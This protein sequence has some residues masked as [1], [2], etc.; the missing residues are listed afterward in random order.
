MTER[1][2]TTTLVARPRGGVAV[3]LPF[4]PAQAWGHRE[5]YDLAGSIGGR[6]VRGKLTETDDGP[7]LLLGPAWCR[8]PA[9]GP[10]STVEVVLA[11]EGPQLDDLPHELQAALAAEPQAAAFFQA[12]PTYYRKNYVRPIAAAKRPQ[13]RERLALQ[14]VEALRE[15]RRER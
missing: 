11:P 13:T 1:R 6:A 15:K 14:T 7:A 4:A 3:H 8:D 5:R 9:V 12:L 2:F 10:G